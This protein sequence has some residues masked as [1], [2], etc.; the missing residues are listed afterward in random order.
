[1]DDRPGTGDTADLM[2][3]LRTGAV[4]DG[5]RL[6]D[7]VADRIHDLV[8]FVSRDPGLAAEVTRDVVVMAAGSSGV[9]QD[10]DG[11]R[12]WLYDQARTETFAILAGRGRTPPEDRVVELGELPADHGAADLAALTYGATAAFSER[13]LALL[14]L[15][16]R[17]GLQ[18][19][20]LADAMGLS[21]GA[22]EVLLPATLERIAAQ[23][24]VLLALVAGA[25]CCELLADLRDAWDGTFSPL[26]RRRAPELAVTCAAVLEGL[27]S[28]LALLQGVP[29]AP[30]PATLRDGVDARLRITGRF[31]APMDAGSGT[32]AEDATVPPGAGA[33]LVLADLRTGVGDATL[34]PGAG[35]P[36]VGDG[37]PDEG[38]A[39]GP[40]VVPGAGDAGAGQPGPG[41]PGAEP[42]DVAGPTEPVAPRATSSGAS[43]PRLP[44]PLAVALG[45][46]VA[47]VVAGGLFRALV[48]RHEDVQGAPVTLAE[49]PS[50]GPGAPA[51]A[52]AAGAAAATRPPAPT[53][54][55]Q[56]RPSSA[57]AAATQLQS[58]DPTAVGTP[59]EPGSLAMPPG[60]L[61]VPQGGTAAL[62]LTNP[63]G[64]AVSWQVVGRPGWSVLDRTSGEVGPG[65]GVE[66]RVGLAEALAEGDYSGPV[67]ISWSGTAP[68]EVTATVSGSVDRPPAL[69]T[70]AVGSRALLAEGCGLDRTEVAVTATDESGLA[71]VHVV[72][73]GPGAD[74]AVRTVLQPDPADASRFVGILGPY[75]APGE[76]ALEVVA[77]DVRG[78]AVE[79]DGGSLAVAPC[80]GR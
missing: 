15:H 26:V 57:T 12:A 24:R 53:G 51:V 31:A 50:V 9:P 67:R 58:A 79:A 34:P 33:P 72:A 61:V 2:A 49:V 45:V 8:L 7:R 47:L 64:T 56:P 43:A 73:R 17:H 59:A 1:V 38:D 11:M 52:G 71:E 75:D 54:A 55:A 14:A 70:I 22:I 80:P 10:P 76:I 66:V 19:R 60:V 3:G 18:D 29:L 48:D 77:E 5:L 41:R 69:G 36:V 63:G 23:L 6:Y 39:T 20:A 13:D 62:R 42:A 40:V 37:R 65:A 35:P 21:E 16:L 25:S 4:E 78:N 30:A 74:P 46:A 32:A 28:P 68:G 44:V 27:P